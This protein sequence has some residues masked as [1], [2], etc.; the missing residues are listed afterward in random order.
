M[1]KDNKHGQFLRE[2]EQF[3]PAAYLLA[4]TGSAQRKFDAEFWRA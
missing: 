1:K 3:G 4:G 2:A